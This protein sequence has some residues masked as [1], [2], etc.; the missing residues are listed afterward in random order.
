L[1]VENRE[2][3]RVGFFF[4]TISRKIHEYTRTINISSLWKQKLF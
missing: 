3:A 4:Y 2:P 1:A